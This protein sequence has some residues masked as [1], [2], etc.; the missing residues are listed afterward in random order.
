M[1][2]KWHYRMF[3]NGVVKDPVPL[4]IDEIMELREIYKYARHMVLSEDQ[5]EFEAAYILLN[6]AVSQHE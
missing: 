5:T 4:M 6:L 3:E 2:N 1:I